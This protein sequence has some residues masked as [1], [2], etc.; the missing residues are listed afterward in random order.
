MGQ[1]VPT[2]GHAA[3]S[4]KHQRLYSEPENLKNSRPK[5]L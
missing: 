2:Y 1:I 4:G 3:P 5:N